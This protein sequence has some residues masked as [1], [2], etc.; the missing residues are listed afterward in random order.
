M[1]SL[2]R[3]RKIYLDGF[4]GKKPLTP[5]SY[6]DLE[7]KAR[8]RLSPEA[9]AYLAGGAGRESTIEHNRTALDGIKIHPRM[10]GGVQEVRMQ[11]PWRGHTLPA[12]LMLA[13]IG[14]LELA[15][16]DGDLAEA[17]AC[18]ELKIPMI[19]SSQASHPMEAI[20]KELGDSPRLFQLYYSKSRELSQSF[21]RR[22]EAIGCSAIVVTLDTTMLGWRLRDLQLGYNPFIMGKGIAQYYSD[23]VFNALPDPLRDVNAKPS[24]TPE[25]ILNLIRVCQRIPGG[26]IQNLKGNKAL[27]TATKFTSIFSNPGITWSDIELIR[28]WTKLPIYLKGVLRTDD[29]LKAISIGVDGIIISNHGGRQID[30]AI[31]SVEALAHISP[32]VKNKIDLWIDSGIRTGSDVYKCLAL[33]ATGV[34]VGRPYAMALA[35]NGAQGVVDCITNIISELE[36]NMALSGC[37]DID[38]LNETMITHSWKTT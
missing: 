20:A 36:L 24:I 32:A 23:P 18:A 16:R 7:A 9:F 21:I 12:P 2:R 10:L 38:A 25:L 31:S 13:P 15:H 14:V 37:A 26:F 22:A 28:S 34:M 1:L 6:A 35:C 5:V 8:T 17:R 4:A 27:N 33:G 19:I 3:Q 11:L 30:G 29:A